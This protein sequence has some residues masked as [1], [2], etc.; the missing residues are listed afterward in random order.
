MKK[1]CNEELTVLVAVDA[2]MEA[3][4]RDVCHPDVSIVASSDSNAVCTF[5]ADHVCH[6]AKHQNCPRDQFAP[7]MLITWTI[8]MFCRVTL[9]TTMKS[10]SGRSYSR[11]SIG[12]PNFAICFLDNLVSS[13]SMVPSG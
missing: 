10:A 4:N 6:S 8:L 11:I 9:S 5:H 13:V 2:S 12:C 1:K 7:F 3:R